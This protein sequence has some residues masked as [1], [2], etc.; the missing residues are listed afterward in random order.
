M[1]NAPPWRKESEPLFAEPR[2]DIGN[3]GKNAHIYKGAKWK[4][5]RAVEFKKEPFKCCLPNCILLAKILDHI[6]PIEQ[7]GAIWDRRNWQKLCDPHHNKKRGKEA[8]G[9][10]EEWVDTPHGKIPKRNAH[11][12]PDIAGQSYMIQ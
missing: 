4:R 1:S 7:G 10:I 3:S 5:L 11:L 8:H 2:Q 9:I 6:I 12:T